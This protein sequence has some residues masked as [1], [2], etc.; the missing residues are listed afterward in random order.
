MHVLNQLR[1]IWEKFEYLGHWTSSRAQIDGF[2]KLRSYKMTRKIRWTCCRGVRSF[3]ND[4]FTGETKRAL[5]LWYGFSRFQKCTESF[6][7]SPTRCPP[8]HIILTEWRRILTECCLTE[9]LKGVG[10]CWGQ[11]SF[12]ICHRVTFSYRKRSKQRF[13]AVQYTLLKISTEESGPK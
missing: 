12:L 5:L 7:V 4:S 8:P 9:G 10:Q 3:E 2:E 1:L 6:H 11:R 13:T